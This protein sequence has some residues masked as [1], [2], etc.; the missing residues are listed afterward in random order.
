MKTVSKKL[1]SL[2]LVAIMLVSA[3]P[4]QAFA[5]EVDQTPAPETVAP[6]TTEATVSDVIEEPADQAVIEDK[7]IV[8]FVDADGS[9]LSYTNKA[10]D[11][12]DCIVEVSYGKT[13]PA[14]KFPDKYL[15]LADGEMIF[16]HWVYEG[17]NVKFKRTESIHQDITLQ[18]VYKYPPVKV[19]FKANGGKADFASKSYEYGTTYADN[20]GLPGAKREHYDFLGWYSADGA[21]VTDDTMIASKSAYSL[22]AQWALTH[23]NVTFQA[24]TDPEGADDSCWEDVEPYTFTV[25]DE[26]AIEAKSVLST[27][28]GTFPTAADIS[29]Y[30]ALE[31]WTIDG[32]EIVETGKEAVSGKT[33]VLSNITIR[34]IYKRSITLDACDTGMTSRKFTV[35]LGKRV[36]A[37][38]N[39]GTREGYAFIG[40]YLDPEASEVVS[41][42]ADLSNVS[43]HPFYYP[44]MGDFYAGWAESKM[45]YL[46]IYTNNNTKDMVKLIRYYDAPA[47][48]LDLTEINLYGLYKDYGKYDDEGDTRHGWFTPAQWK[49][50]CLNPSVFKDETTDYVNGEY[51]EEDDV[52]EFYIMLIDNGNNN[53]TNGNGGAGGYGNTNNNTKDPSNP[54]TGDMIGLPMFFMVATAA[55]AAFLLLNKKRIVK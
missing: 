30:F 45:V 48:G 27:A 1:L 44:A 24:Y 2:L 43:K 11:S 4:F 17:T 36:P 54:A 47:N 10:G 50:Y 52:H 53:A 23:Y 16:S 38:P 34:P 21:L 15:T 32:W 41:L 19:T 9:T 8:T 22:T 28:N 37:L 33:T 35:T 5:A 13:I 25:E 55:A 29:E 46:Y 49:N 12:V 40:W 39:P 51:L 31:G 26:N 18:A 6:E 42:K 20:G 14:A 3:V 7:L